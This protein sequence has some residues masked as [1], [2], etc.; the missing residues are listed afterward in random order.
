M[1]QPLTVREMVGTSKAAGTATSAVVTAT[2]VSLLK[3]PLALT[4]APPG[5]VN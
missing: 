2:T 1:L 3:P 5:K 4:V